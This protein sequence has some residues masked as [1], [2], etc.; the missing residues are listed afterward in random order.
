MPANL[1]EAFKEFK[2]K[3]AASFQTIQNDMGAGHVGYSGHVGYA[4]DDA[5]SVGS[6]DKSNLD[7]RNDNSC[8]VSMNHFLICPSCRER[9]RAMF[10]QNL[11]TPSPKQEIKE[12]FT[13]AMCDDSN[14][15]RIFMVLAGIF[16]IM[17]LKFIRELW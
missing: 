7:L 14:M 12:S 4:A 13:S 10:T 8:D 6:S 11:P 9:A 3:S 1:T 15:Q 16:V 2:F 5:V 17:L